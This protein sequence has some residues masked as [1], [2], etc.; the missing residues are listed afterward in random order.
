M[1]RVRAET[2]ISSIRPR[3]LH[4]VPPRREIQRF[5]L[6][7]DELSAVMTRAPAHAVDDE[8]EAWLGKICRALD[9]DRS[10]I[11]ERDSPFDPVRVT[12]TW[13][14]PKIPPFPPSFN[15]EK[16]LKA[17]T[18]W[19]MAGNQIVFSSPN[20]I[21]P[22]LE[23]GKKFVERYGPKAS[24]IIPMW[25]GSRVIGAASFGKFRAARKWPTRLLEQ[26]TLAVRLFG[27]A[28][29]RKQAE[30]DRRATVAQLRIA[31]RRNM[32]SEV[33]A[34]LAH[35]INQPLGAIMSNLGGLARL[36]A[37]NNPEPELAAQAVSNAIEDTKRAAEIIRRVRFMFKAHPEQKSAIGIGGL[38][39]EVVNLI[40]G[41]ATLR[42]IVVTLEVSPT[43]KRVIG[44]RIQLQQCVMN[45]LMNALDAISE[46]KSNQRLVTIRIVP[47]KPGWA[48]VSVCDS[49]GGI[50]PAV[51]EN[52]F[53]PFVTTKSNGM[54]LGLLVTRSIIQN[55]GGRIWATPNP[56]RGTTFTFTLPVAQRRQAGVS[57]RAIRA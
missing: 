30:A 10:A 48:S 27:S 1:P 8:I 56:D 49:G 57:K 12:H 42:K 20:E 24:A 19:V 47:E 46:S 36:L 37:K 7:V 51:A 22:E 5:E 41:E 16:Y 50:D 45:L 31:S 25:A 35:E 38:A 17:T 2:P 43:V 13:K 15:P 40:A 6:L 53:E 29:E 33:V 4:G 3:I 28:I 52:L 9:L 32:M 44:D 54:G 18:D 34:S 14:R 23:D 39:E 26:I 21:P 55:H 11:Y